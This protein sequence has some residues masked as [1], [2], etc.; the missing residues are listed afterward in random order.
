MLQNHDFFKDD[1]GM[2][3]FRPLRPDPVNLT[4][5]G[6]PWSSHSL[7]E[8]SNSQ[9]MMWD[10]LQ[11]KM[12]AYRTSI[13]LAAK[14]MKYFGKK[15]QK[16]AKRF[17]SKNNTWSEAQKCGVLYTAPKSD[18]LTNR[19]GHAANQ[20][21][22]CFDL[23]VLQV[24]PNGLVPPPNWTYGTIESLN[25]VL[26]SLKPM[27]PER[28]QMMDCVTGWLDILLVEFLDKKGPLWGFHRAKDALSWL[29]LQQEQWLRRLDD[30]VARARDEQVRLDH[31]SFSEIVHETE[32]EGD[33]D[34]DRAEWCKQMQQRFGGW[35]WI[36]RFQ[37]KK[38][39]I[40]DFWI[41]PEVSVQD[42]YYVF[43]A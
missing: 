17:C 37:E 4:V 33:D 1:G 41:C 18:P 28:S 24:P 9:E 38:E 7:V 6:A 5:H 34:Q 23:Q 25:T 19:F 39:D 42:R 26:S 10:E 2:M 43:T 15:L 36:D 40:R 16:A 35:N 12:V 14:D 22:C 30:L 32:V 20:M 8:L 31:D 29:Q 11:T 3:R 27:A 21:G 13:F